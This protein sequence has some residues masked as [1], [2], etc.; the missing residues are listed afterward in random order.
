MLNKTFER[1]EDKYKYISSLWRVY[2]ILLEYCCQIDY[3]LSIA[4][5][6]NVNT[7]EIS[8]IWEECSKKV[9]EAENE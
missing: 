5:I 6:V 3:K 4:A 9:K 7:D 8:S 1:I 2:A